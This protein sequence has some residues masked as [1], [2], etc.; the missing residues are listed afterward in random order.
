[1]GANRSGQLSGFRAGLGK[2]QEHSGVGEKIPIGRTV[3]GSMRPLRAVVKRQDVFREC[4]CHRT[5]VHLTLGIS[6]G[7]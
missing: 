1:M 3:L 7:A 2:S 6:R 5:H 4:G